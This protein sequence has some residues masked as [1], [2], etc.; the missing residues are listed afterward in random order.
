MFHCTIVS[1]VAI[2]LLGLPP[3]AVWHA[4]KCKE[5]LHCNQIPLPTNV[6][7]AHNLQGLQ[8][9]LLHYRTV[10]AQTLNTLMELNTSH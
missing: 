5:K 7:V 8:R 1:C 9:I 2:A 3:V 6:V 10:H 4:T